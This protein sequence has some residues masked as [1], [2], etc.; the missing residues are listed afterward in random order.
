MKF[1]FSQ[2]NWLFA[3]AEGRILLEMLW[4]CPGNT[5]AHFPAFSISW[6]AMLR[7]VYPICAR[8]PGFQILGKGRRWTYVC[9]SCPL[10]GSPSFAQWRSFVDDFLRRKTRQGHSIPNGFPRRRCKDSLEPYS[11]DHLS[12]GWWMRFLQI[13][14]VEDLGSPFQTLVNKNAEGLD[15]VDDF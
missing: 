9:R 14:C 1:R 15:L 4:W 3:F 7:L 2:K 12:L 11:Q 8:Y 5:S 13:F 10:H 6:T